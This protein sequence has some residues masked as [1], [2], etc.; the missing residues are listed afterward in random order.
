MFFSISLQ[1]TKIESVTQEASKQLYLKD[2]D[3]AI[4][5]KWWKGSNHEYKELASTTKNSSNMAYI[6]EI[7]SYECDQ[8]SRP[9]S[10]SLWT[11][12]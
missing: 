9:K 6:V 4:T 3:L 8:L 10:I 12:H 1:N 11:K 2:A 7:E 5:K